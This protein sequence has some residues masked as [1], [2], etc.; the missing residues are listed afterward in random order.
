MNEP[1]VRK[2]ES[3][4]EERDG[5]NRGRIH[6]SVSAGKIHGVGYETSETGM[7]RGGE[8]GGLRR[9]DETFLPSF[10]KAR[11]TFSSR[12]AIPEFHKIHKMDGAQIKRLGFQW[13]SSP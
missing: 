1:Q 5:G 8:V 10:I 7:R 12:V 4:V 2:S 6:V 3:K 11:E 9:G 13:P